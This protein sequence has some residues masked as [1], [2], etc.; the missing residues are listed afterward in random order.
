METFCGLV[1]A[2]LGVTLGIRWIF[3]YFAELESDKT[4]EK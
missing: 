4:G 3:E 1:L 2:V